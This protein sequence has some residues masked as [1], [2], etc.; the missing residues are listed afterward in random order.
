MSALVRFLRSN[1]FVFRY[2]ST[3]YISPMNISQSGIYVYIYINI[4]YVYIIIINHFLPSDTWIIW[5]CYSL[6]I[7]WSFYIHFHPFENNLTRIRTEISLEGT[8]SLNH[9]ANGIHINVY[10]WLMMIHLIYIYLDVFNEPSLNNFIKGIYWNYVIK[11]LHISTF[12]NIYNT[13]ICININ[14]N[15]IHK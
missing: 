15:T 10:H 7:A 13:P 8:I 4:Y 9:Y 1:P 2:V 3:P 11:F 5:I 12:D 14:H 6:Q